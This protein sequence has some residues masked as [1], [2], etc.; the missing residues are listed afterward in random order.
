MSVNILFMFDFLFCAFVFHFMNCVFILF[1]IM[2]H[3]LC[4]LL[5][6]L[7][8]LTHHCHRVETQLQ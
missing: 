7:Y 3:L 4:R 2:F 1:C 6:I 8:K 5:P